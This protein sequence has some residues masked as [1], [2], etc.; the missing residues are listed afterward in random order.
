MARGF[1]L[2]TE[3]LGVLV[4]S[5]PQVRAKKAV[6]SWDQKPEASLGLVEVLTLFSLF[7]T[8]GNFS[9]IPFPFG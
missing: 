4:S 3:H 2:W 7:L 6:R 8:S 5:Y 9:Y 1:L